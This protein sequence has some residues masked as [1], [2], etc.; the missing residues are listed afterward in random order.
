[1]LT[2]VSRKE[3]GGTKGTST[4]MVNLDTTA[5]LMLRLIAA[6]FRAHNLNMPMM[7]IIVLL[8]RLCIGVLAAVL[9][10]LLLLLSNYGRVYC[11]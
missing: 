1:V 6:G 8:L 3:K 7:L 10:S 11:Y 4:I 2:V 5:R 9:L